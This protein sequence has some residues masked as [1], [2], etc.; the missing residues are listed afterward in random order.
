M[1]VARRIVA[2]G[3][4]LAVSAGMLVAPGPARP[5]GGAPLPDRYVLPGA[6]LFPE[7][8]G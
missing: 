2:V 6:R 8:I 7:S 4:A 5:S 3:T 1:I